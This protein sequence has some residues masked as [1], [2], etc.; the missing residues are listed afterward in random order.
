MFTALHPLPLLL[1]LLVLT[2]CAPP[3]AVRAQ[4][5]TPSAQCT[6]TGF[7]LFLSLINSSVHVSSAFPSDQYNVTLPAIIDASELIVVTAANASAVVPSFVFV[8]VNGGAAVGPYNLS[9]PFTVAG[10]NTAATALNTI[11]I[12]VNASTVTLGTNGGANLSCTST[13]VFT[14]INPSGS[15]ECEQLDPL[16]LAMFDPNDAAQGPATYSAALS[17]SSTPFNGQ[18]VTSISIRISTENNNTI[19]LFVYDMNTG[20]LFAQTAT[21]N[22]IATANGAITTLTLP[23]I[24]TNL[25]ALSAS[26]D[27]F[28]GITFDNT[29]NYLIGFSFSGTIN[30]LVL[31]SQQ[32]PFDPT[33][34]IPDPVPAPQN[35]FDNVVSLYASFTTS[36]CTYS[37]VPAIT[38]TVLDPQTTCFQTAFDLVSGANVVNVP[39]SFPTQTYTV[40]SATAL[41]TATNTIRITLPTLNTSYI[42]STIFISLNGGQ[43]QGPFAVTFPVTAVAVSGFILTAG[44]TNNISI[45]VTQTFVFP[46]DTPFITTTTSSFCNN[47][48]TFSVVNPT[49]SL[50]VGDPLIVGL[51]GQTFQVHGIDGAVYNLISAPTFNLNSEFVFLTG[52]RMCPIIP[53][54][55]HRAEACWSHPGSYLANVGLVTHSRRVLIESGNARTGFARVVVDGALLGIGDTLTHSDGRVNMSVSYLSTHECAVTIGVFHVLLENVDRFV[56]LRTIEVSSPVSVSYSTLARQNVHG[57]IGQTWRPLPTAVGKLKFI[58]G[59]STDEYLLASRDVFGRDFEYNRFKTRSNV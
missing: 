6:E 8:S 53:S 20:K 57:L 22:V 15:S 48:N 4:S 51:M 50:M 25:T 33:Q 29:I 27:V 39:V 3:S 42:N 40:R 59:N 45:A 32:N 1:L 58:E 9:A 41:I 30:G 11:A 46:I 56:N 43:A 14:L 5:T 19:R 36:N 28:I 24:S 44:A 7:T 12:I 26:A 13:D 10:L 18:F 21:Y 37:V 47:V 54:T 2:L 55:G 31:T 49:Q 23:V 34:P 38:Q 35:T 16:A 52:P 17:P